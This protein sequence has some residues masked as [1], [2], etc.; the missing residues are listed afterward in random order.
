MKLIT[1]III[2]VIVMARAKTKELITVL[3]ASSI[4]TGVPVALGAIFL[5]DVTKFSSRFSSRMSPVGVISTLARP[6]LAT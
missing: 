1:R 5:T 3:P 2:R 6:L 4:I